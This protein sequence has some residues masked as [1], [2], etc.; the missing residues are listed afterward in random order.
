MSA[1]SGIVSSIFSSDAQ[2]DAAS[3]ASQAQ[4]ASAKY[5]ADMA[6]KSSQEALD[7]QRDALSQARQ[8]FQP[9]LSAG[10]QGLRSLQRDM[11]R[12]LQQKVAPLAE[13]YNQYQS[14]TLPTFGDYKF[15]TEDPVYQQKLSQANESIDKFLAKQGLQG[16]SAGEAFRQKQL[17][18]LM[19]DDEARQYGRAT[20][21]YNR[22]L[23]STLTKDQL[24]RQLM[25]SQYDMGANQYGLQYAGAL[26]QAKMGAGAANSAGQASMQGGSNMANTTTQA[27]S[28][29]GNYALQSGNAQ[30]QG[31]LASGQAQAGLWQS[32]NNTN[33]GMA[34]L[35]MQYFSPQQQPGYQSPWGYGGGQGGYGS[36]YMAAP[37]S[38]AIAGTG[39]SR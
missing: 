18:Q 14:P 37:A 17:N 19:V 7:F 24:D 4:Q 1:L 2:E 9:Y 29:I 8:D 33:A 16:S 26:D 20:D 12:Y 34:N 6:Y 22:D 23:G 35:A 10:T 39:M 15:N 31:A 3:T 32:L 36:G 25:L 13:K 21:T 30:A 5:A 28:Q 11:P 38:N 27:G